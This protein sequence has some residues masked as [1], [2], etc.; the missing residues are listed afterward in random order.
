MMLYPVKLQNW[1]YFGRALQGAR[2]GA[3]HRSV[4]RYHIIADNYD[5]T[6]ELL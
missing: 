3:D 1:L 2:Q 5:L 6:I 4:W